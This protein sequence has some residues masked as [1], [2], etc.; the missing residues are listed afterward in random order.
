MNEQEEKLQYAPEAEQQPVQAEQTSEIPSEAP[1]IVEM[2][3][4][5]VEPIEEDAPRGSAI[6]S[7]ILGIASL[8]SSGSMPVAGIVLAAIARAKAK[9]FLRDYPGSSASGFAKT[10]RILGNIGLPL[11]IVMTV[12]MAL[13]FIAGIA[14]GM[15]EESSDVVIEFEQ[16]ILPMI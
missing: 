1:M 10:G 4:P 15:M 2:P 12:V 9:A 16:N 7:M 6:A 3:A 8:A 14:L 13:A 11:S 5:M